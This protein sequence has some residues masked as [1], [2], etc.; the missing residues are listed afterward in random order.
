MTVLSER[1]VKRVFPRLHGC[2]TACAAKHPWI[3][4]H[5][6][7]LIYVTMVLI[8]ALLTVWM[9]LSP[10]SWGRVETSQDC[11]QQDPT[12]GRCSAGDLSNYLDKRIANTFMN[13]SSRFDIIVVLIN[14]FWMIW[15]QVYHHVV[16]QRSSDVELFIN[17]RGVLLKMLTG[18]IFAQ[19]LRFS[20]S[21]PSPLATALMWSYH[22]YVINA[23]VA[24]ITAPFPSPV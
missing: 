10:H 20:A 6:W 15:T 22:L 23:I 2:Y 8:V 7:P 24:F 14:L 12:F 9:V 11:C 17:E 1:G 21:D 4:H 16:I 5:A 13:C 19:A 18:A 3:K